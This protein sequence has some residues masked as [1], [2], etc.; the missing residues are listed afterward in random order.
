MI[1]IDRLLNDIPWIIERCT[2][3]TL[4]SANYSSAWSIFFFFFHHDFVSLSITLC[5]CVCDIVYI[6]KPVVEPFLIF[7]IIDNRLPIVMGSFFLVYFCQ[8]WIVNNECKCI[9]NFMKWILMRDKTNFKH[10]KQNRENKAHN[11]IKNSW[12]ALQCA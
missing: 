4:R 6:V 5:V 11:K 10:L 9:K 12:D 8:L 7:I 2:S 3:N 1:E